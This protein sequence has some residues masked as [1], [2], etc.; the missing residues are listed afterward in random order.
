MSYIYMLK[1]LWR[2]TGEERWKIIVYYLLHMIATL[3]ELGKP[4][5]FAMVVNSLQAN[6]P[7]LITDVSHWLAFYV[8][9]YIIFEVFHRCARY[10]EIPVAFRTR[11][12]FV[13]AMYDKL[14]SLPLS[15]HTE[16][17][18]GNLIDRVNIS[19]HAI[20]EFGL[21]QMT[22]IAVIMKF[23][24]PLII[25]WHISP[26]ISMVSLA[27]GITMIAIT[28]LMYRFIVPLY[29][30]A[31]KTFHDFAA[32]FYDYMS[33]MKT[34]ITLRLGKH[35]KQDLDNRLA[36]AFPFI[37]A[38]QHITQ[39]KCAA[40]ALLTLLLEVGVI[41]YY[42]KTQRLAGKIIMI[43]SVT[44]IFQYLGQLMEAFQFYAGDYEAI[45]HWKVDLQAIKPI[46][47]EK[48]PQQLQKNIGLSEWNHI[49]IHP[50]RFSHDNE[51]MHLQDVALEM[52]RTSKIALVGESGSGKST[53]LHI[54]R[55]LCDA[56][57]AT[58][59]IDSDMALPLSVLSATTTLI[60]QEPEIFENTIR[61]NITM[62]IPATEEEVLAAIRVAG[63]DQVVDGLPNGLES[64]IRE[65]GVNL[66]GGERQRLAL[67]RGVLSIQDS[68]V[69]LL[70]EPTSN[71]DPHTEMVIF[72]RLFDLLENRCVV[73]SLHRLHLV[74]LFD[75]VYVIK[76]GQL[77]EEGTFDD[78]CGRSGEFARLWAAYQN[79]TDQAEVEIE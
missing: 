26:Q 79:E 23:W 19:A 73:S 44:A 53:L 14:Q 33:N 10:I 68:S 31:I 24:V 63:F 67:A 36:R 6:K 75:Y 76:Q 40:I 77:V 30:G 9:C 42:I 32:A 50:I 46:I 21:S 35:V 18:S 54:L 7:S 66:S 49:Q 55:G 17:H 59:N 61:H 28:R 43:G 45:I 11:R 51:K 71:I 13:D 47:E 25:L 3:G 74:R 15:W 48:S 34:I 70:D 37:M 41:F 78:L 62:G 20:Y 52:S 65:K 39:V 5:A 22:Y 2:Y 4:Y 57:N 58:L 72:E 8:L 1:Q 27:V 56:P 12:R 69:V 38:E 60:P 29:G 64:D 16:H